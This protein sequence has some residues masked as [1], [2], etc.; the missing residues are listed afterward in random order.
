M[1]QHHGH[2]MSFDREQIKSR[3]ADLASNGV[4]IGTSSWK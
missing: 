4:F 3:M 1:G 2:P